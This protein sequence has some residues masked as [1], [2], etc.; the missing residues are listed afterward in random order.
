M[1]LPRSVPPLAAALVAFAVLAA[2]CGKSPEKIKAEQ[3]AELARTT[4]S[5]LVKTNVAEAVVKVT[6]AD[7]TTGSPREGAANQP[8]TAVLPGKYT[9]TATLEGWPEARTEATVQTGQT[10]TVTLNLPSGS[11]RL[12]SAPTGVNVKLGSRELGKTPLTLAQL[13]A[14]ETTLSLEYP[15]WPAVTH[16]VTIAENTETAATV[17]LPHGKVILDTVPSGATVFQ[18]KTTLGTTPLTLDAVPAG[19]RKYSFQLKPF[20]TIEVALT[21]V[22]GKDTKYSPALGA[23]FPALDPAELLREVW[24][25][26]DP[27][28][29]TTGFNSTTGIYRPRNDIVK[30]IHRERLYS[31]WQLKF[32]R[33]TGQVKEYNATTGKVEFVEG[34]AEVSRYRVTALLLKAGATVQKDAT[35]SVYGKLVAVEEA[36]WPGRIITLELES[37]DLLPEVTK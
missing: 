25:P 8:I 22:D 4:G 23:F 21:V 13:P 5:V 12:D 17:R 27:G 2:G 26:D 36:A 29:I 10:T 19:A 11:L 14:G 16:K 1:N 7:G 31:R 33:Y 6:P 35:I 34:K 32:Y 9:V 15:S 28:K 20:P 37:A 18:G 30:N 24:I 3:A